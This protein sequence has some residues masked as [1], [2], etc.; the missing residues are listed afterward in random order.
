MA[1]LLLAFC[2]IALLDASTC[3][4]FLTN[5]VEFE[6]TPTIRYRGELALGLVLIGLACFIRGFRPA[7]PMWAS[8][9][10]RERPWLL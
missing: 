7:S 3:L 5:A 9:L 8:T 10:T 4:T 6:L 1:A 2:G